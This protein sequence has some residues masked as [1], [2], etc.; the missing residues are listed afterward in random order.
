[1]INDR[2][3]KKPKC[4]PSGNIFTKN[5]A[6]SATIETDDY[7]IRNFETNKLGTETKQQQIK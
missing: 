7:P 3:D 1:V 5:T 4:A 6:A 2:L